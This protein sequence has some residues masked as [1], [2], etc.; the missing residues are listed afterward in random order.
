MATRVNILHGRNNFQDFSASLYGVA[1][2]WNVAPR[3]FL[4]GATLSVTC[5]DR[6]D[7]DRLQENKG[8]VEV[9][10]DSRFSTRPQL[11]EALYYGYRVKLIFNY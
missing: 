7:G 4:V 8:F 9:A 3:E 6:I 1:P 2:P 11:K 5:H 10:A